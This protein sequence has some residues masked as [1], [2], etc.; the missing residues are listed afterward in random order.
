M[1]PIATPLCMR[2]KDKP[3]DLGY[4][5]VEPAA[6]KPKNAPKPNLLKQL[7]NTV[8]KNPYIWGMALTYFFIYIVRQVRTLPAAANTACPPSSKHSSQEPRYRAQ[9]ATMMCGVLL[10]HLCRISVE[11][12]HQKSRISAMMPCRKNG[13]CACTLLCLPICAALLCLQPCNHTVLQPADYTIPAPPLPA[14]G[15]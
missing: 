6:V 10:V 14:H 1:I 4:P 8:L 15:L 13:G 3:E 5:A 11:H 9:E 12:V 2:S 7:V